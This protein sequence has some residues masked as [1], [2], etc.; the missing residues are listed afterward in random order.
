M[1]RE[2]FNLVELI[3]KSQKAIN[4]S[5]EEHRRFVAAKVRFFI[6]QGI[7]VFETMAKLRMNHRDI[8]P[9]NIMV[10]DEERLIFIDFGCVKTLTDKM[11]DEAR[12]L[13][14]KNSIEELTK[15]EKEIVS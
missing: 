4:I 1:P 15:N 11:I 13:Y 7:S 8:K 2:E 3:T 10:R 14:G 5:T 12:T 6:F 9:A